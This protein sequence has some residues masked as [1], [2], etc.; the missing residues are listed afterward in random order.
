MTFEIPAYS[1]MQVLEPIPITGVMLTSTTATEA[2]PIWASGTTYAVGAVV[3][4]DRRLY[5][6]L[7]A[8]A[9][10]K[11]PPQDPDAWSDGGP[12]NPWAMFDDMNNTTT[13]GP[14]GTPLIVVVR[15]GQFFSSLYLGGLSG[16]QAKA[17]LRD[18][19]GG[20]VIFERE[21]GLYE[22]NAGDWHEYLF[23]P[24]RDVEDAL[25][26]GIPMSVDPE[27]TI[28][29]DAGA[30]AA[31]QCAMCAIGDI[32]TIGGTQWGASA[33]LVSYSHIKTDVFG[34]TTRVKRHSAKTMRATVY[35]PLSQAAGVQDL[36][37]RLDARAAL[38]SATPVDK[39]R[40][41]RVFG[42][43]TGDMIFENV[44][45]A[46]LNLEAIGLI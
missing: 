41:L 11:A 13:T 39:Y 8:G 28:E 29:I 27:L 5:R 19:P 6:R 23:S 32:H 42:L 44:H 14:V 3:Q 18:G 45:F 12:A 20:T 46:A 10:A 17:T 33:K 30:G 16:G 22:R 36:L 15:P 26:D 25:I 37:A 35:V 1:A 7:T 24:F 34:K 43:A 2:A 38:W 4:H 9:G 40:P 31:A 21:L